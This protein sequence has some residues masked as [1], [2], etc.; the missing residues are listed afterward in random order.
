MYILHEYSTFLNNNLKYKL[1][2][3]KSSKNG[4]TGSYVYLCICVCIYVC[5][6]VY[7]HVHVHCFVSNSAQ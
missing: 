6:Y 3:K 5:E 1:I 7:V 2:K 4:H